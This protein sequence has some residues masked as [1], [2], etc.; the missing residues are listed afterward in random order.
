MEISSFPVFNPTYC[1]L[2]RLM[3]IRCASMRNGKNQR[4]ASPNGQGV[5]E[6]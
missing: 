4:V 6:I 2:M 1:L 3:R 5:V